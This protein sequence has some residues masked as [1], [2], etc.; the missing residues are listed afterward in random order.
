MSLPKA[1]RRPFLMVLS[2]PSGGGK[3]TV[4]QAVLQRLP[5]LQRCVTATTRL[6][7]KGERN[8][9]DYHFLSRAEF[10]KRLKAGGFYEHAEVHGNLYGTPRAEVEQSL[11]KGRSLILVIDVQGAAQVRRKQK[12]VVT[13]FLLPPSIKELERRLTGRG[14]DDVAVL[15]RRLVNAKGELEHAVDYQYWV[16]ND[17]L[18][19]AVDE[20]AAIVV[21]E[22]LRRPIRR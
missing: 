17:R 1:Q 5:Y 6:P 14:T 8:G 9:V 11:K 20:V 18:D 19:Q 4:C 21:A 7:R 13:V 2:A 3:T 10:E 12:D 16:V 22:G 15:R